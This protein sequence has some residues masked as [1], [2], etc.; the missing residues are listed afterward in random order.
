MEASLEGINDEIERKPGSGSP[1]RP[2]ASPPG[3]S[4]DLL[5]LQRSEKTVRAPGGFAC[6]AHAEV[7]ALLALV[8]EAGDGFMLADG[9]LDMMNRC[10]ERKRVEVNGLHPC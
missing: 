4:T 2:L 6:L 5:S 10:N 7:A 3:Q 1:N 8:T 9:T